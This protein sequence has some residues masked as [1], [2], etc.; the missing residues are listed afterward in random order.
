MI[1]VL[2]PVLAVWR[3]EADNQII[4][5]CSLGENAD[6]FAADLVSGQYLDTVVVCSVAGKNL[7]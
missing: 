6:D 5:G 2:K 4:I 7:V 3:V 1:Y